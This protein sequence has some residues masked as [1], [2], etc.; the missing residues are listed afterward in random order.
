MDVEQGQQPSQVEDPGDYVVAAHLDA[1]TVAVAWWTSSL[2]V[3]RTGCGWR[4]SAPTVRRSPAHAH[5]DH[6]RP[7]QLVDIFELNH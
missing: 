7:N 2:K 6:P 4:T 5:R 3:C 1:V